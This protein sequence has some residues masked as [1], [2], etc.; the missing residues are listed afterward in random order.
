M[1]RIQEA[2]VVEGK[3]DTIRLRSA[4][5]AVIVETDGF[6]LFRHTE[7]LRLIRRLAAQ[8]GVIVLTD[9]DGAG[10]VIRDYL[11]SA[12]PP[13]QIKHAY[14]PEV[15][16]K[17]RRKTAASKEGLLGVE[18]METTVLLTALRRAGATFLEEAPGSPPDRFLSKGDLYRDGL[19]GAPDSAAR[20]EWLLRRLE[21][22]PKLSANRM[23]E[24]FNAILTPEQYRALLEELAAA[25]SSGTSGQPSEKGE[26][27]TP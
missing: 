6:G 4:V 8:R 22:P 5:D 12:L 1:Y 26:Q 16:G 25:I 27:D 19:S 7:K 15:A 13:A 3:Y 24:V 20:R 14:I 2:L 11:S 18:G 10:F 23:L 17:E 9:S 21:L